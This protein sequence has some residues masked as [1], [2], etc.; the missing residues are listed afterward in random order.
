MVTG[1]NKMAIPASDFNL[2]RAVDLWSSLGKRKLDLWKI[3]FDNTERLTIV[4]C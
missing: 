3:E 2:S 1:I 4:D